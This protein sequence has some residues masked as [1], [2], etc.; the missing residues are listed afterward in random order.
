[1]TRGRDA[2]AHF[3]WKFRTLLS[4]SRDSSLGVVTRLRAESSKNRG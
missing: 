1:M 4:T 3:V 2:S